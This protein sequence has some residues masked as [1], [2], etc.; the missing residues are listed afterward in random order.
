[1]SGPVVPKSA[2]LAL[3]APALLLPIAICLLLALGGLSDSTGDATGALVLA[4]IARAVGVIWVLDLV[5]LL[6]LLA[7]DVLLRRDEP[8]DTSP[9]SK[10]EHRAP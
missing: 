1:M 7:I 6:V 5:S 8:I 3:L 10:T 9:P 4:W 2:L